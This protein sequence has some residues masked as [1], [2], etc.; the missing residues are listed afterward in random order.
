MEE[1]ACATARLRGI[2]LKQIEGEESNQGRGECAHSLTYLR[3]VCG[4]LEDG[5]R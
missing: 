3:L 5:P 2:H 1:R 4:N